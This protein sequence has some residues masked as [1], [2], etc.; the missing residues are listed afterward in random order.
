A[1]PWQE[2]T[3]VASPTDASLCLGGDTV[4]WSRAISVTSSPCRSGVARG[5]RGCCRS[6]TLGHTPSPAVVPRGATDVS[7]RAALSTADAVLRRSP[8]CL[9]P[10][11]SARPAPPARWGTPP[12]RPYS[13][14]TPLGA[15]VPRPLERGLGIPGVHVP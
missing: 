12:W 4:T 15:S 13:A 9:W 11:A 8:A 14:V 7:S 6:T 3:R 5:R 2:D 10:S 1:G